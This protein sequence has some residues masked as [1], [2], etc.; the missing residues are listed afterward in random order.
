[1]LYCLTKILDGKDLQWFSPSFFLYIATIIPPTWFLELE[2]I[3]QKM[4]ALETLEGKNV[5]GTNG[6]YDNSQSFNSD[7]LRRDQTQLG[8]V[9]NNTPFYEFYDEAL[10]IILPS[11]IKVNFNIF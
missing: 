9:T 8:I 10:P 2:N 11:D 7:I 6:S 4:I 1:M 5:L 3:R